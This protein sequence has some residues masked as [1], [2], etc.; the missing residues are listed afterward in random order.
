M[1][2]I[3]FENTFVTAGD[4]GISAQAN[5]FELNA[6]GAPVP[7]LTNPNPRIIQ[8]DQATQFQFSWAT[9]GWLPAVFDAGT[10]LW[11]FDVLCELMGPGEIGIIPSITSGNIQSNS[12]TLTIAPNSMPDGVV[13]FV[14]RMMLLPTGVSP[15]P[16]CGFTEFPLVEYY[17]S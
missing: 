7:V 8:R 12:V 10:A 6:A 3:L 4:F 2:A 16:I 5:Y 9:S 14:V 11:K 1:A 15:C 17:Q 13:R